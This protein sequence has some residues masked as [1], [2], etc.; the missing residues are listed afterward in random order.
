MAH[1]YQPRDQYHQRLIGDR[2][3]RNKSRTWFNNGGRDLSY[4]YRGMFPTRCDYILLSNG[5]TYSYIV[6]SCTSRHFRFATQCSDVPMTP[7]KGISTPK[8]RKRRGYR[9][10][11]D[12]NRAA[13][14]RDDLMTQSF[15]KLRMSLVLN[16][17]IKN[18]RILI[19]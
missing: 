4:G 8:C 16:V 5:T 18:V 17:S 6:S 3:N 10:R 1:F 2:W 11:K 12:R 19:F 13:T 14:R 15:V 7:E 9:A